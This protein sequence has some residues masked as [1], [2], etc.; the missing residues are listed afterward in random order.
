MRIS[1]VIPAYNEEA[2][3]EPCLKAVERAVAFAHLSPEECEILLVN[4]A[5]TDGTRDI[6]LKFPAVRVVD[7]PRK[8][9]TRARQA[10]FAASSGELIA[11]P[12]A[13]TQMPRD[14]IA[15]VLAEFSGDPW[16]MALSGPPLYYDLPLAKRILVEM[17][18][19]IAF[20]SYLINYY[21]LK[22]GGMLQGGNFVVRRSAL[23]S[24]GGYDTSIEFYGEDTDIARR[25]SKI[26]KVRWTWTLPMYASGRRLMAEGVMTISYRYTLNYLST[27]FIKRPVT[28]AYRDI[29]PG[30]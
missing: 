2:V 13:D 3:L 18:I 4:N 28:V 26:G 30:R 10:G 19:M 24:I 20:V 25:V 21:V 15:H 6:A 29:R 9:L 27:L 5:S 8:G 7:E 17:L 16:L 22:K 12:D 23:E 11:N 1:I 14:W